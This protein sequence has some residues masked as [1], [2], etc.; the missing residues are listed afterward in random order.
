MKLE[1]EWVLGTLVI[2]LIAILGVI[3]GMILDDRKRITNHDI[4]LGKM[5]S[6][7]A[8]ISSLENTFTDT[9]R[10]HEDKED[11]QFNTLHSNIE[12]VTKRLD[13]FIKV[14]LSKKS[15]EKLNG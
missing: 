8:K 1:L 5:E 6:I 2:I 9:L 7:P 11:E 4:L 15:G 13:A 12:G 10:R 3:F 14:I